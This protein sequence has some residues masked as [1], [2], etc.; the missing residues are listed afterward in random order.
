M[1]PML[2]RAFGSTSLAAALVVLNYDCA[3]TLDARALHITKLG[4]AW[5]AVSPDSLLLLQPAIERHVAVWLWDPVVQ[6]ILEQPTWLTLGVL[7]AIL[8]V[9]GRRSWSSATQT[10]DSLSGRR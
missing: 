2:F 8:M 10:S 7:G 4:E 9:V 1:M 5:H 3:K 6:T